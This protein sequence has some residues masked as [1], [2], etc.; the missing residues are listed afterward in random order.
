[1]SAGE[2]LAPFPEKFKQNGGAAMASIGPVQLAIL[3]DRSAPVF[4]EASY[5]ISPT[6]DD[7]DHAQAYREVVQLV[8]VDAAPREDGVDDPIPE[9]VIFDETLI[10]TTRDPLARTHA[11]NLPPEVLDEDGFLRDAEIMAR[12][13]LTPLPA[14]RDSNVVTRAGA[15]IG[16][17]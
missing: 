8:G 3:G 13:T 1:V 12:V 4:V 10:L 17:S 7:V 6:N 14:S 16:A 9:G 15:V 11:K 5:A 2:R